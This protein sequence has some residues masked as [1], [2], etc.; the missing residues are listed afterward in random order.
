MKEEMN[1]FNRLKS[2]YEF[3]YSLDDVAQYCNEYGQF[4]IK[5]FF[6]IEHIGH[7]KL[8]ELFLRHPHIGREYYPELFK[9][10]S[11]S[12]TLTKSF[13]LAK[14]GIDGVSCTWQRGIKKN[15]L[16]QRYYINPSLQ[17]DKTSDPIF[18][19][20][21]INNTDNIFLLQ[22]ID[23]KVIDFWTELRGVPSHKMLKPSGTIDIKVDFNS[24]ITSY[25]FQDPMIFLA[26][27]PERFKIRLL[28][29]ECPGNNCRIQLL[30]HFIDHSIKTNVVHLAF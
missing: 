16:F 15:Q 17:T 11:V 20:F 27:A 6:Q 7:S 25:Q 22:Q 19:C 1:W 30:F 4:P 23:I 28:D 5:T 8:Q 18:D 14:L 9:N 24:E 26:N 3:N 10:P 2:S 21:F 13:Y 12:P 29:I